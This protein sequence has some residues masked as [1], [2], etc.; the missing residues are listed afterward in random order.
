MPKKSKYGGGNMTTTTKQLEGIA[1]VLAHEAI[2]VGL[3]PEHLSD[4]WDLEIGDIAFIDAS[5]GREPTD[6]ELFVIKTTFKKVVDAI[7]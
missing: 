1:T 7:G 4:G 2:S 6:D 3:L 5:L